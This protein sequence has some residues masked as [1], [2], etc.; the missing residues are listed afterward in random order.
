MTQYTIDYFLRLRRKNFLTPKHYL[1]FISNYLRLLEEKDAYIVAQ[2]TY[3]RTDLPGLLINLFQCERL[4]GGLVK[5]AEASVQLE[6]LNRKLEIQRVVVAK[7]TA[8]CEAM[9]VDIKEGTKNAKAKKEVASEK[10]TEIE[11]KKEI[12]MVEQAEAEAVLADAL[13]ALEAAKRALE[14]LDKSDI[15]EIRSFATPP[16][17][18]QTICECV[19]I[20]RGLKEINW[21]T[22]KGIMADPNFLK[23]LQEMNC[24]EITMGQ[25]KAVKAHMKKSKKLGEMQKISKAGFGLLTFVTAVL[26]YCEVYRE[27]KPKKEKVEQLQRDYNTAMKYLQK[28]YTEIAQIEEELDKLNDKYNTAMARRQELQEETEIMERRLKAADTLIGGLSSESARWT[29]DL[30]NLHEEQKRLVG[31]CLLSAAFLSYTG[32]FTFEFRQTMIY[33]DWFNDIKDRGIPLTESYR[34]ETNLTNDVEISK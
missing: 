16:E 23:S 14:S 22:A 13:P 19:A 28:L 27:V 30:E 12:I 5:I 25:Q 24:D 11:A 6:E 21:K 17:P 1:D 7:A 15:T 2:V 20:L 31:N 4:Q 29:R 10:S 18:V 8:E 9:L 33:Q 34:I 3:I 26:G 32:P